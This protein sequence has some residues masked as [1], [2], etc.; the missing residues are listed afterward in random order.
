MEFF[1]KI[2]FTERSRIYDEF[3]KRENSL[4]KTDSPFFYFNSP[5]SG[6]IQMEIYMNG[7]KCFTC[8]CSC[9]YD[10][11]QDMK[12]WLEDIVLGHNVETT[13]HIDCEKNEVYLHYERLYDSSDVGL[14]YVYNDNPESIPFYAV[15]DTNDFVKSLYLAL[16]KVCGNCYNTQHSDFAKEWYYDENSFRSHKFDNMTFYNNVKSPLLD[17]YVNSKYPWYSD[18]Y[19]RK[20]PKVKETISMWCDY[21]DALFWGRDKEG[22]GFCCGDA[23]GFGTE[24][25]G[26]FNL[27]TIEGLREWYDEWD[28]T[29][30]PNKWTKKQWDKWHERGY[31]FAQQ[32]R[33]LLP[34]TIDL[35]YYDWSPRIK[36]VRKEV[37]EC[38]PMIVFNPRSLS[39]IH[40]K[41]QIG[42]VTRM[43][44]DDIIKSLKIV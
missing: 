28:S 18:F 21:A 13:M 27:E 23:G 24:T 35:Y 25:A 19:F 42:R 16:L 20:M 32:I 36:V 1:D 30:L 29:P 2:W 43:K 15:C 31:A 5:D 40:E 37:G 6:W 22:H 10:P 38:C 11:F 9:V 17:L 14:F 34:D 12:R 8:D 33:E 41:K 3:S 39:P 7:K 26:D 4:K 44:Y